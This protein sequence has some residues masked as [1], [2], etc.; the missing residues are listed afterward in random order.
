LYLLSTIVLWAGSL[1]LFR[2]RTRREYRERGRL[3]SA[4]SVLE[5]ALWLA[6]AAVPFAYNPPC[7]PYV[8]TCASSSHGSAAVAGYLFIT[9]GAII[10]FGSMIW[11]GLRRSFGHP[12]GELEYSGPYRFSRN[13]QVVGGTLMVAGVAILW[14]SWYAVGWALLW[15]AMFH[16]MVLTEEE[17]LQRVF[18]GAYEDYRRRVPRY[19]GWH[20]R[21]KVTPNE[22]RHPARGERPSP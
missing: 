12:V 15:V 16:P 7:W 4:S 1:W 2:I 21:L 3:S 22:I 8:W 19:V 5:L 17:H 14:P 10:G 9:L 6:Y 20:R 18:A 13:P 11:L